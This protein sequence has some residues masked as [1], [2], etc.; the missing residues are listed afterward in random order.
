MFVS[1]AP[2]QTQFTV[3]AG[4]NAAAADCVIETTADLLAA[5]GLI[6]GRPPGF[7]AIEAVLMIRPRSP[8]VPGSWSVI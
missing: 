4:A 5:Y 2:G 3:M 8:S 1:T 7:P 6:I